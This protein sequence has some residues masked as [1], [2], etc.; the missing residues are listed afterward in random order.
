VIASTAVGTPLNPYN[1]TRAHHPLQEQAGVPR[2]RFHDLHHPCASLLLATCVPIHVVSRHLGHSSAAILI[3]VYAHLMAGQGR[4]AAEV[5][6]RL[7]APSAPRT[8]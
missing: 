4:E 7:L 8:S 5:M 6:G 2:I 3:R 1:I